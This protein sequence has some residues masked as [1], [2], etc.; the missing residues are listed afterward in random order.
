MKG[1]IGTC[2]V[3]I[4]FCLVIMSCKKQT[5]SSSVNYSGK[6]NVHYEHQEINDNTG[7]IT[8][9]QWDST[10]NDVIDV[11]VD[12]DQRLIRFKLTPQHHLCPNYKNEYDFNLSKD[13][14]VYT[15]NSNSNENFIF[16]GNTLSRTFNFWTGNGGTYTINKINFSGTK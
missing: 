1:S 10:Y 15:I 9:T 3:F 8:N 6:C 13:T 16:S 14:Y 7:E 5:N 12:I 11:K 2:I 4:M